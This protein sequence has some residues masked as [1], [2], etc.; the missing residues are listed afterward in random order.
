MRAVD[1]HLRARAV[2]AGGNRQCRPGGQLPGQRPDDGPGERLA[3][4]CQALR[5]IGVD[6]RWSVSTDSSSRQ[7]LSLVRSPPTSTERTYHDYPASGWAPYDR[8]VRQAKAYGLS[9]NFD[10]MG[11]APLWAVGRAPA[12]SMVSVWYPSA[13]KLGAFFH[14][15]ASATAGWVR[16]DEHVDAATGRQVLEHLERA[17]CRL[18][19]AVAPDGS[20]SRSRPRPLPLDARRGLE[21]PAVDGTPSQQR[22]D[23][24]GQTASTGHLNPGAEFGMQPLRFLRALYCVDSSYRAARRCGRTSTQVPNHGLWIQ[25][26]RQRPPGALSGH[27]SGTSLLLVGHGCAEVW[28]VQALGPDW[29]TFADLPQARRCARSR[30]AHL[31]HGPT[32]CRY[33]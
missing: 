3:Q 20:R 19:F 30:P 1:A 5:S 9:V 12:P 33:L 29:V 7:R 11:G 4:P 24:V 15:W 17:E 28:A 8:I 23:V 14:A 21:R 26:L 10:V 6:R 27:R 25:A 16:T 18:Q 32:I 22:H 31:R 2:C 13:A